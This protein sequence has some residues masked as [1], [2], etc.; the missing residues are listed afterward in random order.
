LGKLLIKQIV[1][2]PALTN[3]K[4]IGLGTADAHGLYAQFG[5]TGLS[6]PENMMEI[7]RT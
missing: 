7:V 2:H 6:K 4:R 1:E 5:F 3:L